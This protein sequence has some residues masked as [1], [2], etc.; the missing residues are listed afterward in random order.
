MLINHLSSRS[1]SVY[2]ATPSCAS[3]KV[4][5]QASKGGIL[6]DH[7]GVELDEDEDGWVQRSRDEMRIEQPIEL[8]VGRRMTRQLLG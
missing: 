5:A 2:F 8:E 1:I 7:H 3:T 4:V 6:A